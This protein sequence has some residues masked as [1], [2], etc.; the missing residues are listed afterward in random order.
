[1][2]SQSPGTSS[3]RVPDTIIVADVFTA[4]SAFVKYTRSGLANVPTIVMH[5]LVDDT[6]F[7]RADS[8]SNRRRHHAGLDL[9]GLAS[10]SPGE[11]SES[12]HAASA[13]RADAVAASTEDGRA[14]W[15][16]A[17][18]EV[19]AA[20]VRVGLGHSDAAWMSSVHSEYCQQR[21]GLPDNELVVGA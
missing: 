20:G 12:T 16:H 13:S 3:Q 17:G 19:P 4:P 7:R 6:L 18:L 11:H 1:M 10:E 15:S 8:A 14:R 21:L 5:P 9:H 2:V